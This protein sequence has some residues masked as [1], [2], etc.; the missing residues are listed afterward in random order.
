VWVAGLFVLGGIAVLSLDMGP[1]GRRWS[2]EY[3]VPFNV[4]RVASTQNIHAVTGPRK[5]H[6]DVTDVWILPQ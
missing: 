3:P 4:L 2:G 5:V 6:A 1:S